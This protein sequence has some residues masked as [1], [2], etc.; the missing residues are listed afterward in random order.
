METEKHTF[1]Y[2]CIITPVAWSNEVCNRHQP[3]QA[4]SD[5]T[6]LQAVAFLADPPATPFTAIQPTNV[7]EFMSPIRR[8]PRLIPFAVAVSM[9]SLL[10]ACG[11]KSADAK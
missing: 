5:V 10:A 1:T 2:V 4:R 3:P 9:V 6:S 8:L 11:D 7:R